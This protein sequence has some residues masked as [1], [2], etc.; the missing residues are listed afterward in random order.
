MK[1]KKPFDARSLSHED[2]EKIRRATV[3]RVQAGE[4]PELIAAGMGLNRTTVYRWLNAY[5]YGGDDALAA[6]PIPG[7]PRKLNAKQM[8]RI[9]R[10][11][12]EK[13]P[14]QLRFDYALWT[15]AMIRELIVRLFDVRLSEVSVGRLMRRMG[16]TPQRPL[17][18]AWQQDPVLVE[19]WRTEEYPRIAAR[20][21]REKAMVFFADE[22][23]LRTDHHAGTTWAPAGETPIVAVTGARYSVNMISAVNNLGHFRFMTV[24]G[25]VN[26][27]VFRD[28][29]QRLI[30]GVDR[31]IFLIVDGHPTHKSKTVRKFVSENAERIELIFLPPYAPQLN[32]D[33]QAWAHVKSKVAKVTAHTKEGLKRT[34]YSVMRELQAMPNIVASFF[35]HP[36]CAYANL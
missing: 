5:H 35:R 12:R 3:A 21:K 15:L 8:M 11:V 22:S 24:D 16:F 6:K 18:R 34:L 7:A 13:N 2:L 14:Q 28:F 23:G 4:S 25:A 33:E 17:Y 20:A 36:D 29:L 27:E 10:I 9:A 1:C 26:G 30:T 19:R 32:P 31:K